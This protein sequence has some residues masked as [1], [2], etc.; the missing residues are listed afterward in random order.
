[1]HLPEGIAQKIAAYMLSLLVA[2]SPLPSVTPQTVTISF[3]GDVTLSGINEQ[4]GDSYSFYAYEEKYP[5]EYYFEKV[6]NI[7]TND[8]FTFINFEGA[9]TDDEALK[10]R[11]KP[12]TNNFWFKGPVSNA[13]ILTAGG[14]DGVSLSNNHSR[15]YGDKGLSDTIAAM[16]NNAIL[17]GNEGKTVYFRKHG[18]TFAIICAWTPEKSYFTPLYDRLERERYRSDYQI[19]FLHGGT[20]GTSQVNDWRASNCRKLIDSG[21]DLIINSGPHVLQPIERYKDKVIAYSLGNFCFGGNKRPNKY[22]IILQAKFYVYDG[23]IFGEDIGIFP[24]YVYTEEY[25]NYQPA[26]IT[27]A[28]EIKKV[29]DA[30]FAP[31]QIG[32]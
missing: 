20:E 26:P 14:V 12:G 22:T 24:C 16:E 30:V 4:R 17:W 21:A 9:L 23:K 11:T 8:D 31:V 5:P 28:D 19:L 10:V 18:V 7:F 1:M 13:E 6:Q 3:T 15:D 32:G 25:N 27:D 29:T 2:G